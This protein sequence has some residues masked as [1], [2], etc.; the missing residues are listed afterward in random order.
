LSDLGK[1]SFL[2]GSLR[3]KG[4]NDVDV[5]LQIPLDNTIKE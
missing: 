4:A 3:Y 2:K 1:I 5:S